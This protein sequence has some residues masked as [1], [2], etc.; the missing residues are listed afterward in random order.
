[1][2]LEF[3]DP[4]ALGYEAWQLDGVVIWRLPLG[5]SITDDL[6]NREFPIT[7]E[8]ERPVAHFER[9]GTLAPTGLPA[10]TAATA[11]TP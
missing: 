8:S 2:Q 10:V 6:V 1:L 3:D 11:S 4:D 5:F 7:W 9:T